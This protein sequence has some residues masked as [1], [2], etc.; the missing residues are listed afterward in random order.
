LWRI[1]S[2][3]VVRKREE[4]SKFM[5]MLIFILVVSFGEGSEKKL[6]V[7]LVQR[8]FDIVFSVDFGYLVL[9]SVCCQQASGR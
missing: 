9:C 6:C 5:F 8:F 7:P 3:V 1:I 4:T 2:V